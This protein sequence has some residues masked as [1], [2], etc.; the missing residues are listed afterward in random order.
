[1]INDL[2]KAVD[3]LNNAGYF[4]NDIQLGKIMYDNKTLV[5]IDFELAD[6]KELYG[7]FS[8]RNQ[9]DAL[10]NNLF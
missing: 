10:K 3:W 9:I 8:E 1:M 5:L 6:T 2:G 7:R 4:H